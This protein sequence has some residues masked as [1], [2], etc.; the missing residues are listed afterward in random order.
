MKPVVKNI[1]SWKVKTEA[2][3]KRV[4]SK[5]TD[6]IH[7]QIRQIYKAAVQASPQWS[8]N[9]AY[10]SY[11]ETNSNT[12]S[13]NTM[14]KHTPWQ[15]LEYPKQVGS[16]PAVSAAMRRL[17]VM[18]PHVKWNSNVRLVNK[19]PVAPEIE[20]GTVNLRPQNLFPAGEGVIQYLEMRFKYLRKL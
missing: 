11:V 16:E 17:D 19:S 14:F 3:K 4:K 20:A 6:Y 9:Y 12:A 2:A 5:A 7:K 18:L 15:E 13:W 10:N 8:G 1:N